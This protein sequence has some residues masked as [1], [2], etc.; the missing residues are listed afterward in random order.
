MVRRERVGVS[1]SLEGP[2]RCLVSPL[3]LVIILEGVWRVWMLVKWA[4]M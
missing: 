4:C 1:R 2:V 3:L